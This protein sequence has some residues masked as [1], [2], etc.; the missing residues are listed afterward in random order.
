MC[1]LGVD[2]CLDYWYGKALE[3]YL[4]KWVSE[5]GVKLHLQLHKPWGEVDILVHILEN[6]CLSMFM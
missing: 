1:D 3:V 4:L 6:R 2:V 5:C